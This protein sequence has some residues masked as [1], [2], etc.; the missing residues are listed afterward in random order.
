MKDWFLSFATD[1]DPNV[2]SYTNVSK[3]YWPQYTTPGVG[4][5]SIMDVN[6]TMMGVIPDTDANTGC[7]FFHGQSY[8]VRN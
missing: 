2:K 8:A 6:Y 7:D 3:P 5:L 4:N 1:L